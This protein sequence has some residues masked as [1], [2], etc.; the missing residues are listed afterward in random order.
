MKKFKMFVYGTLRKG[1]VNYEKYLENN[2]ISIEEAYTYG[3]MYYLEKEEC[4][5]LIDGDDKVYGEIIECTD[6]DDYTLL[7]QV[8]HLEKYF[9]DN[10]CIMYEKRDKKVFRKDGTSEIVPTYIFI[11]AS[12][13]NHNMPIESGDFNQFSR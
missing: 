8:D 13:I 10:S 11:N 6:D 12:Y 7:K 4:P 2:V 3:K 5:A 9:G 1:N